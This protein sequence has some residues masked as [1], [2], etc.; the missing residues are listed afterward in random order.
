[1]NSESF[2]FISNLP[3]FS[4]SGFFPANTNTFFFP[5]FVSSDT[6]F[7]LSLEKTQESVIISNISVVSVWMNKQSYL[8]TRRKFLF[9]V[10]CL[11]ATG[12]EMNSLAQNTASGR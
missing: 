6:C 3:E 4:H 7:H 5:R 9:A 12:V 2:N 1:M 8:D 10:S 11:I